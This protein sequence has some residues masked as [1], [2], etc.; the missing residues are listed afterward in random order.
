MKLN[1][2]INKTKVFFYNYGSV[3]YEL[4]LMDQENFEFEI[5]VVPIRWSSLIQTFASSVAKISNAGSRG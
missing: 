5:E 1:A 2:A 4:L 3:D